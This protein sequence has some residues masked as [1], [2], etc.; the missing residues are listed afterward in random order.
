ME[1]LIPFTQ[2][3]FQN[4]FSLL[5]LQEKA[6]FCLNRQRCHLEHHT[7]LSFLSTDDFLFEVVFIY[8]MDGCLSLDIFISFNIAFFILPAVLCI[9]MFVHSCCYSMLFSEF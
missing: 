5:R 6:E 9:I 7:L 4:F 2:L 8:I 3:T 1:A